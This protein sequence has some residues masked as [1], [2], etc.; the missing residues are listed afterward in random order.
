MARRAHVR[1]IM[2]HTYDSKEARDAARGRGGSSPSRSAN[3]DRSDVKNRN[4]PA[5][6][7]DRQNR[8]RQAKK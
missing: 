4:N 1:E 7:A 6:E 2:A 8:E 5:F 3:D